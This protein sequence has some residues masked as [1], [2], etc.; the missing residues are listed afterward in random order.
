MFNNDFSEV[1]FLLCGH[2]AVFNSLADTWPLNFRDCLTAVQNKQWK[3]KLISHN[4]FRSEF[5]HN[6]GLA[7]G[8]DPQNVA[9]V[10]AAFVQLVTA[11][12]LRVF[13]KNFANFEAFVKERIVG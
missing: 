11:D 2:Q 12:Y 1:Y 8:V 3:R 10:F 13:I 4:L 6:V 7:L 9:D 5:Q